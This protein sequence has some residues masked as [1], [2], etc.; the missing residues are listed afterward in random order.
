MSSQPNR[1][2][3]DTE[4]LRAIGTRIREARGETTQEVFAAMIGVTRSALT[5]YEAGRRLPNDIVL[6]KISEV[7][8]KSAPYIL[9]GN[10][11]T[12]F[13]E[14]KRDINQLIMEKSQKRPGFIPR[15]QIS[16][17]EIALISLFRLVYIYDNGLDIVEYILKKAKEAIQTEVE[18]SGAPVFW[19]MGYVEQLEDVL[20]RRYFQ[21]GFDPD[22]SY[23]VT[24]WEEKRAREEAATEGGDK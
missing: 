9:F 2:I 13:E 24:F 12:P 5:N 7:S 17:D 21:E 6:R 19:G 18:F 10:T 8:G 16:D 4:T 20:K 14:Y 3:F 22:F 11:I 1:K 15:F 23:W